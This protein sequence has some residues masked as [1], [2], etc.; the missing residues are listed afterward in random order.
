MLAL[1]HRD[2][3][4]VVE[5]IS[6]CEPA[7]TFGTLQGPSNA[8]MC[9][10]HNT[11]ACI[12]SNTITIKTGAGNTLN[13]KISTARGRSPV[14]DNTCRLMS[15]EPTRIR[16]VKCSTRF[17]YFVLGFCTTKFRLYRNFSKTN[18]SVTSVDCVCVSLRKEVFEDME[19]NQKDLNFLRNLIR[20]ESSGL[21]L[22]WYT[23]RLPANAGTEEKSE[24]IERQ[25]SHLCM[26]Y[27]LNINKCQQPQWVFED[28]VRS[29]L[30]FLRSWKIMKRYKRKAAFGSW[31]YDGDPLLS[32]TI[33]VFFSPIRSPSFT[34]TVRR[35]WRARVPIWHSSCSRVSTAH[36]LPTTSSLLS[37]SSGCQKVRCFC[38]HPGV[39]CISDESFIYKRDSIGETNFVYSR[40]N[41]F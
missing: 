29:S 38:P 39:Q 10:R 40:A 17:K 20:T 24:K 31:P 7:R 18:R 16:R 21:R 4:R 30:Q 34:C 37:S 8:P 11:T 35:C 33:F 14:L 5:N 26:V 3:V 36:P 12:R 32:C 23:A 19:Y 9:T 27:A 1:T 6:M 28:V 41:I 15:H 13:C 25:N 22:Q 2:C